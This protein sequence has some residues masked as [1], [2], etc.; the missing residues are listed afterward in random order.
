MRG[1]KGLKLKPRPYQYKAKDIALKKKRAVIVM[2]T[3][4]GKTLVGL[5][6][7]KE[8]LES[9]KV[10]KILILEPT[11]ILV[12]QV[13]LFYRKIAGMNATP[14]HGLMSE[15]AKREG[16]RSSI[17]VTTPEEMLFNIEKLDSFD[18][19]IVDECHHSVGEDAFKKVLERASAEWRLGLSAHIPKKYK[20]EIEFLIGDIH[21]WKSSDPEIA[22]YIPKWIGE[23][24]ETPLSAEAMRIYNEIEKLWISAKGR[25][26]MLYALALRFLSRDG[27]LALKESVSKDT[28]L[29]K[30]LEP[31]K[32]DILKL[33]DLHKYDKLRKVLENYDFDKAI[34]FVDRVIVAKKLF[35][36]LKEYE[37]VLITGRRSGIKD[38]MIKQSLELAR[39]PEHRVIIS[40]SAGEEGVDLPSADL[41]V[42]WSNV[43]SLLRFIQRHG[44]ILRKTKPLKYVVYLVTPDTVDMN[45]FLDSVIL[46]KR[47][48]VDM[49]I[50]EELVYRLAKKSPRTLI[51]DSLEVPMPPE[52][53]REITGLTSTDVQRGLRLFLSEG[54]IFY[55]YTPLGKTIAKPDHIPLLYEEH[56]EYF[57]PTDVKAKAI[58]TNKRRRFVEG[59]FKTI[60]AT[61]SKIL[62]KGGINGLKIVIREREDAVEYVYTLSYNFKI[63]SKEVL[64]AVLRNAFSRK[65]YKEFG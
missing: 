15:E 55:V 50:S 41:L 59:D 53:I 36:L 26:K 4:T 43:A 56:S 27:A 34:I 57:D 18:A 62:E 61:L 2:P 3:G 40:T 11:R 46:A 13:A 38:A 37:P 5:L 49:N 20:R 65:T 19:I 64:E 45:A 14:I 35:D 23:I 30:L 42:L 1:K 22:P 28:M 10:R 44:R 32:E 9:G 16:W 6:W 12:E 31:F 51:I 7:A 47:A 33:P 21:E 17:V 25:E 54:E 8:L 60:Y 39:R 48:G 29:A 24:Y 58:I 63:T 52:W